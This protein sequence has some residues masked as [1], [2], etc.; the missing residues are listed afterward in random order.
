MRISEPPVN[1]SDAVKSEES[2]ELSDTDIGLPQQETSTI[3][4][5]AK[6][7]LTAV[8][9]LVHVIFKEEG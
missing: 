6:E 9:N 7:K 3:L 1:A 5:G 4:A 2:E 8:Q